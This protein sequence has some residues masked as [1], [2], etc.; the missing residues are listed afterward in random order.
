GKHFGPTP[1]MSRYFEIIGVVSDARYF[2][3]GIDQ[4]T[5]P[6]YFTPEAQADYTRNAGALFLH[7]IVIA[8]KPGAQVTIPQVQ[9]AMASVD[10]NMPVIS[11]D[12]VRELVAGQF[13]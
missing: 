12:T 4:P 1:Q 5:G 13:T 7:D 3:H 10:P 8:A 6:M 11:I 9:D 2:T